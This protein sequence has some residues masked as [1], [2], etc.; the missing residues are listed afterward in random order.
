MSVH[1]G[2]TEPGRRDGDAAS[3]RVLIVHGAAETRETIPRGL[4]YEMLEIVEAPD[5]RAAI[6]RLGAEPIDLILLEMG[7]AGAGGIQLLRLLKGDSHTHAIPVIVIAGA[8]EGDGVVDCLEAGADDY[9][10]QP[11]HPVVLRI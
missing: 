3:R 5:A 6:D 4:A 1:I 8:D 2:S 9:L 7:G 10:S 11:L